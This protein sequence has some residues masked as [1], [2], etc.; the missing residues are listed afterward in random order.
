MGV[1]DLAGLAAAAEAAEAAGCTAVFAGWDGQA[2]GV[3]VI[4]DT[5]KPTSAEAIRRLRALGLR[6]VLLTGDNAR[7]A[8]AAAAAVGIGEVIAGVLPEGKAAAIKQLQLQG[9]VVAM[10]GD[11]INDAAALAQA[12]LGLAMGT[13]TDAAIEASDLTLV[14]GDLL[15]VPDAIRCPARTLAT[16]KAQPVLGVRLQHRGH[17]AG[18]PR[19]PQPA[20]RRRRDGVSAPCSSS[21][22]ACGCAVSAGARGFLGSQLRPPRPALTRN[23]SKPAIE[24]RIITSGSRGC[25]AP[26]VRVRMDIVRAVSHYLQ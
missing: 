12:D 23:S 25:H 21:P 4:A 16:I 20:D 24:R 19:T 3:L 13:G 26:P 2:R 1:A 17:P 11:G 6:P 15:A 8:R 5:V 7:A 14:R 10:V 22:T 18:R 9:R